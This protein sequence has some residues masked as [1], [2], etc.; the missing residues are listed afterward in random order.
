VTGGEDLSLAEINEAAEIVTEA[1]DQDANIIFGAV[2]DT[3]LKDEIKITVIATG[4][5][6]VKVYNKAE[7]KRVE[8]KDALRK[9]RAEEPKPVDENQDD[10]LEI[11]AFLRNRYNK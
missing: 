11:P 9:E 6:E 10:Q 4:F 3:K 1:A 5:D 2:I 8:Q 7:E